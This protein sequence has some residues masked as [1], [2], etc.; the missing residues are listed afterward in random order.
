MSDAPQG[1]TPPPGGHACAGGHGHAGHGHGHAHGQAHGDQAGIA[2]NDAGAD[3]VKDP[4]LR[5][6]VDPAYDEAPGRARR[7]PLLLL[8][9]RLPDQ[10][11]G[12]PGPLRRPR[13]AATKADPVPEGTIYTCP[14]HPEVRQVGPGACPICGMALEP[15][16]VGADEGPSEELVDM[17]RRFWS[18]SS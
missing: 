3:R 7:P 18:G 10:V 13:Q 1:H 17:T 5:D 9:E 14:M 2:A 15:A 4:G 12:R 8:L 11:R 16:M 6:V